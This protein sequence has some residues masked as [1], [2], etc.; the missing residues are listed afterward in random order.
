MNMSDDF[1]A[2]ELA[3]FVDLRD[4]GILTE[5][6]FEDQKHRLLGDISHLSPSANA[7]LDNTTSYDF[8]EL[9]IDDRRSISAFL[10]EGRIP[11]AWGPD[12][13]TICNEYESQL[14]SFLDQVLETDVEPVECSS[15]GSTT[16]RWNQSSDPHGGQPDPFAW[17]YDP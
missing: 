10:L 15:P 7:F 3:K 14:E 13:L 2:D 16:G 6:E 12:H 17:V 4:S 5:A 9:G 11:H 1:I 8:S